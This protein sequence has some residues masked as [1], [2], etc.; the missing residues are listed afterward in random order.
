MNAGGFWSYSND[1]YRRPGMAPLCLEAQDRFGLDVNFLLYCLYAGQRGHR[2]LPDALAWLEEEIAPWREQ[3]VW[4]LRSARRWIKAEGLGGTPQPEFRSQVL[5]LELEAERLQQLEM[6]K[7]L[8]EQAGQPSAAV[9]AANL[10]VYI[11]ARQVEAGSAEMKLFAEILG[12]AFPEEAAS[13]H[14]GR[15]V[16]ALGLLG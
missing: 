9:A 2:L 4:P 13:V 16:A 6:E 1:V 14:Q 8:P 3:A 7:H 12:L 15:L 10:A 11:A 5:A